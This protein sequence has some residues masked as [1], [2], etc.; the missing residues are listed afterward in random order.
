MNSSG[1]RISTD[2]QVKLLG[3]IVEFMV[4]SGVP[5]VSLRR[6]FEL[7]L[8]HA[9]ALKTRR[10][11][12]VGL[13]REGDVIAHLLRLWHR[14]ARYID[15]FEAKPRPLP[16]G[17]GKNSVKS[18]VRRLDPDADV[19]VTIRA[20]KTNRLIKPVG[21][22]RY[23]PTASAAVLQAPHPWAAEHVAESVCRLLATVSRNASASPENPPLLERYSYVP[24]LNPDDVPSFVEFARGQ[25]QVLL[26]TLADWLEPRRVK[27]AT[28]SRGTAKV[29]VPAGLHLITFV[30][31]VAG[32]KR[33]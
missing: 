3:A 21:N 23:L 15:K 24:D 14:D 27:R 8:R 17:Q 16:L 32:P 29:G 9:R 20:M 30:G 2:V 11:V 12:L 1:K 13:E 28:S 31:N 19:E 7:S 22:G 33:A 10:K 26:D 25:G 4:A 5:D 6:A 18:L